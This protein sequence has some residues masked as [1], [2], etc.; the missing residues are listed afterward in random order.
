MTE[1]YRIDSC[2]DHLD[3]NAVPPSLG[4][5][6]VAEKYRQAVP[7]V[8]AHGDLNL[9]MVGDRITGVSGPYVETAL[10]RIGGDAVRK[11]TSDNCRTLHRL[12]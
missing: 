10:D 4:V 11:V 5:E 6:R 12:P 2:D 1:A 8:V 9:W 7:H 3:M